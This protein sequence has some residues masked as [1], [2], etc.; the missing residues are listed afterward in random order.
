[1]NVF[2]YQNFFR[3]NWTIT[4]ENTAFCF[5]TFFVRPHSRKKSVVWGGRCIYSGTKG[6]RF[7]FFSFFFRFLPLDFYESV[8]WTQNV[9]SF[10]LLDLPDILNTHIMGLVHIQTIFWALEKNFQAIFAHFPPNL[11]CLTCWKI[12]V[13]YYVFCIKFYFSG[14]ILRS[15]C[16]M[17]IIFNSG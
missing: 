6:S 3:D 10:V 1:M 5:V 17:I 16:P 2:S 13:F 7:F 12:A 15:T 9:F 14:K 11:R 4:F 8:V